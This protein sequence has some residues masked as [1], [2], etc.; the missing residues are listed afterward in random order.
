MAPDLE[1]IHKLAEKKNIDVDYNE[2]NSKKAYAVAVEGAE[3]ISLDRSKI[4]SQ[5]E[6]KQ[7]LAEEIGHLDTGY[8][9]HVSDALN[10]L[11]KQ[12]VEKAE[13]RAKNWA[14]ETLVPLKELK[15]ALKQTSDIF[16]LAEI[17]D[18]DSAV[19]LRAIETYRLK[20]FEV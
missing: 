3:G 4:E 20:G 17:F 8:V 6:E 11:R 16:E 19:I 10:P 7:I 13:Y 12:N 9:Y 15:K 2:H 14:G 5:R 1:K 18:V